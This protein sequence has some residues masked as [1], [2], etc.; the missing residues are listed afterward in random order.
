MRSKE[1]CLFLPN[2]ALD[3][4]IQEWIHFSDEEIK[5]LQPFFLSLSFFPQAS[6]GPQ[7]SFN[8]F[9]RTCLLG[10]KGT[11][12]LTDFHVKFLFWQEMYYHLTAV[13]QNE[14]MRSS[15][16]LYIYKKKAPER[17]EQK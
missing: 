7:I 5:C 17:R 3:T 8:K 14:K 4:V 2:L 12:Q 13:C 9:Q 16:Q 6:V 11:L 10:P 1:R 15:L